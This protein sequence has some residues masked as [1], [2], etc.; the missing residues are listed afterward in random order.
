MRKQPSTPWAPY[1][2]RPFYKAHLPHD[3]IYLG[4]SWCQS[5]HRHLEE[6]E[7]KMQHQTHWRSREALVLQHHF[8]KAFKKEPPYRYI[9]S[10]WGRILTST[11]H[12]PPKQWQVTEQFTLGQR[13][14]RQD[15]IHP[16][17]PGKSGF[18]TYISVCPL[19]CITLK[20]KEIKLGSSP[21]CFP[22]ITSAWDSEKRKS[23]SKGK[24]LTK[25]CRMASCCLQ[26]SISKWGISPPNIFTHP[27]LFTFP[28]SIAGCPINLKTYLF[29]PWG[30]SFQF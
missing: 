16:P 12:K 29:T 15:Q 13:T 1:F 3:Q 14:I 7:H 11:I 30:K 9:N 6:K 21:S 27:P 19:Y 23:Y 5:K 25:S 24:S 4:R 26:R 10:R 2:N 20:H 8:C 18:T 17:I 28:E 22:E